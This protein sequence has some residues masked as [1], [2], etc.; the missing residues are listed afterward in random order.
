MS[1]FQDLFGREPAIRSEAPGRVNLMGE[2]T[3]YNGGFVL[4]SPIPQTTRVELALRDGRTVRAFS[5]NAADEAPLTYTLGDEK[6]GRGW[7]DFVQGITSV[8]RGEGM[9]PGGFD[10]LIESTVPLGGGV[11]SSASLSV[12]LFRALRTA[13]GLDLDDKRIALLGQRVENQFVG[14]Q[15]GIMDPMAVSLGRPGFALFLDTRSLEYEHVPLPAGS[16]WVVIHSGVAH[17]HSAGDYNTRRAECE[18]ACALL[19]VRQLRDLTDAEPP[20]LAALPALLNRRARH[21]VTENA[22][23]H[24]AVRAMRHG[25]AVILGALFNASHESQRDDYA[26]SV[27]EVDRLAEL[28]RQEPD[29]YGCRLTGGG[30]GGSVVLLAQAGRGRAAAEQAAQQYAAET[31]RTPRVL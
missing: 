10:V 24:A 26:V 12:A 5:A 7:L 21:V 18:R 29:V 31:G 4:P 30:F 2:H 13:F 6:P 20:R 23:V 17:E 9:A 28:A 8:L 15:V 3:D 14:A 22:R 27:P 1:R 19:G 11:S 16:E 25:D